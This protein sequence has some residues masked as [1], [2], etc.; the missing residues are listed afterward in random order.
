VDEI[1]ERK[2]RFLTGESN[3]YYGPVSILREKTPDGATYFTILW[4]DEEQFKAYWE[5]KDK[6]ADNPKHGGHKKPYVMV[7]LD[8]MREIRCANKVEVMGVVLSLADNIEWN[9]GNLI[10]K[11]PK[12]MLRVDDFN[13]ILNFK[14]SKTYEILRQM[15]ELS[16]VEKIDNG[17]R[18]TENFMQRGAGKNARKNPK[19]QN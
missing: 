18:I 1:S 10:Q 6:K 17:F 5:P 15:Q 14:R 2:H 13:K 9:T 3:A 7:M 16:I 4:A 19:L 8:G 12:R 11:R